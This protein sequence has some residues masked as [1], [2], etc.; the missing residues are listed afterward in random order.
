MYG[1][2][3]KRTMDGVRAR[4]GGRQGIVLPVIILGLVVMSTIAV[5]AVLTAG[6]EQR[7]SRAT[8]E[9]SLAFYAAE[10]GLNQT[11]AN[12]DD[13]AAQ[14]DSLEPGDSLDLGWQTLGG[15]GSY[16]AVVM[17]LDNDGGGQVVYALKAEGRGAGAMAGQRTLSLVLT[18]AGGSGGEAYTLGECCEASVTIRGAV[19]IEDETGVDGRDTHPPG[20][21][22]AGVCSDSTYDKPGFLMKDT[23]QLAINDDAWL[24]G[25]PPVAEDPSIDDSSFDQLG[26]LTWEELAAMADKVLDDETVSLARPS[27]KIV[28][29]EV[30]CDTSD[31]YNFGS[32]DPSHPC[33]NYFPIVLVKDDVT[34]DNGYAQG[35][36]VLEWDES[37]K[38]GSEFDLEG[39]TQLNGVILG[40]GCVEPE[41]DSRVYGAIFIDGNYRN[42]DLCNSDADYE[43]DDGDATVRFSQC[44]IDRVL[45]NSPLEEYAEP[46]VTDGSGGARMLVNRSF[47]EV[48]Q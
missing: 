11:Y 17:R 26:G 15:G 9:G 14:V 16:R 34:I 46:T 19:N 32:D 30:V 37:S 24:M 6:D 38:Q 10:A 20:W 4:L 47:V 31:P 8:R 40:K 39:A 3:L 36:F 29:G 7:S 48:F 18:S 22:A 33:F 13:I 28:G 35:I 21:A 41:E 1:D 5:A 12:W 43:M 44:A 42:F 25:V 23:T 2:A 27:T 45:T